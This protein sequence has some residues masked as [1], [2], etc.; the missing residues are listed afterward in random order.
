MTRT[1]AVIASV[2]AIL[3]GQSVLALDRDTPFASIDGGTLALSHW[4]GQPVLVVNTASLCAF[5]GQYA[6]L[7]ALYDRYRNRGLVVLAVPSDDF[8]QELDDNAAVKDFCELTYGIDMP[9]TQISRVKGRDAHPFY[10][11]LED[12]IGFTPRWNFNKVLIDAD[13]VVVG[14]FGSQTR[15]L[16]RNLISKI[17]PLLR[18]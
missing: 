17:E 3:V 5:S 14:T 10:Q 2:F 8:N 15:P 6:D 1:T 16:S 18:Q 4:D 13:G 7:Q 9:M 12:E 11:S